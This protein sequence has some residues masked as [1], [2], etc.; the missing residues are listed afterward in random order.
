ME[1]ESLSNLSKGGRLKIHRD[2]LD[3]LLSNKIV[4]FSKMSEFCYLPKSC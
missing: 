4:K 1:K 3:E 2:M